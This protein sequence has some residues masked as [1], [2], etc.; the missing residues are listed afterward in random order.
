MKTHLEI[1]NERDSIWIG[2]DEHHQDYLVEGF[3]KVDGG[4]KHLVNRYPKAR[5]ELIYHDLEQHGFFSKRPFQLGQG[6]DGSGDACCFALFHHFSLSKGIDSVALHRK[7]YFE[8]DQ[9]K[10]QQPNPKAIQI[11]AEWQGVAYPDQWTEQAYQGLIKSL[12]GINNRSLVQV[13]ESTLEELTDGIEKQLCRQLSLE[14][15]IHRQSSKAKSQA[16][17]L[18][19]VFDEDEDDG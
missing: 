15:A 17:W 10:Y 5:L 7:A 14:F 3:R 9:D 18:R 12:L 16:D 13:L 1:F 4:I 19:Q 8:R 11:F 6:C 2:H